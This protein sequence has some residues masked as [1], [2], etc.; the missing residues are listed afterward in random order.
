MADEKNSTS[1]EQKDAGPK[2]VSPRSLVKAFDS[3]RADYES[4]GE[5]LNL[6]AED[7][8]RERNL[9]VHSVSFRAKEPVRLNVQFHGTFGEGSRA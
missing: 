1:E 5:K 9:K 2:R 3:V 7:L 6:L 4:F 8:L